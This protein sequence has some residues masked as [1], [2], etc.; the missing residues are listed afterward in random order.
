MKILILNH[1]LHISGV[2]RALVN[3]ANALAE[4]GHDV[5]VKIEINDFT[6]ANLLSPKVKLSLLLKEP[7]PFGLR[8][9]G[10]LRFYEK[11]KKHLLTL[12]AEKQYKK[13]VKEKYDVEMAFNRGNIAKMI[14]GSNSDAKKII[15]VHSDYIK[16]GNGFA[17]FKTGDE[18]IEAYKKF[19]KILCVSNQAKKSF[20][21]LFK[22]NNTTCVAYNLFDIDKILSLSAE[23]SF[24]KK[25]FTICAVGRLHES[26]NYSLL[27]KVCKTLND[28]GLDF[29]CYIVGGGDEEKELL[30]QKQEL[31]LDNVIFVGASN[32]PYSYMAQSDIYISTSIYEG[33][34]TTTIE[35]LILGKPCVVTNCT[36]MEEIL[37]ENGE[38]YGMIVPIDEVAIADAVE[39]IYN[40]PTL[41][42]EL[43]SKAL[44]RAKAFESTTLY[45]KIIDAIK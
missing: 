39:N 29:C 36:G 5:T 25:K 44:K 35:A 19:D 24:E 16:C 15:W 43:K 14:S 30:K 33:L 22:I 12:P 31:G 7:H 26:K 13:V 40:S 21:E 42:E 20:E 6:L 28:R 27:L 9:K 34:S 10:F 2:S 3:L 18:A 4:N 23:K 37:T 11:W 8:V 38:A 45:E 1:G 41:A 17:G 32:N